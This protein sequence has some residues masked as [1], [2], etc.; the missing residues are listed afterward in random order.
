MESTITDPASPNN[1]IDVLGG[2]L[3]T[4][5]GEQL[6]NERLA[7]LLLNNMTHLVKQ[8]KLNQAQIMQVDF[9]L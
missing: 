7:Q 1:M 8:G 9:P 4:Q 3:K 5:T 6:S 2:L